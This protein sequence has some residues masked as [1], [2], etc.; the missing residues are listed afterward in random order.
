MKI[1]YT[2]FLSLLSVTLFSQTITQLEVMKSVRKVADNVIRNTTYLYFDMGTGDLINDLDKYGYNKNI[3]PQNGYNDWKYWNGVIHIGFNALGQQTNNE[4]YQNYTQKNFEFF[5]RDFQYLKSL[6]DGKNQWSFPLAQGLNITQLDDC[7]AIGASLIELYMTD[8]KPEYR[9]YIDAAS[10]HIMKKQMRLPDGILSRPKPSLNTVWADDLYMSVPFLS[11]MG[12]LTGDKTYF[13][14]A[15]KQVILFNKYLFEE[16]VG[17]MWHCYYGDIKTNGGAFWGR[18]NGWMMMATADLLRLMPQNH[19]QRDSIISLLSRQI[20]NT[21]QYQSQTGLWHQILNKEDSYLET[22]CTAMFTYAV[23]LAINNG[24][25]DK[26]YKTVALAGWKGIASQITEE[27]AV[28]NICIGTG[29]GDDLKF[30]Y[31]RPTPYN[32]I[33]GL[34]AILLAGMEVYKLVDK[35]DEV[36]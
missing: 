8:K 6:Y 1:R 19:P 18:C 27:G 30:Y 20:R 16:K 12:K 5:F 14:E 2:I 33:H 36:H 22:S 9:A 29:I 32:D 7:G 10:E 26:R 31:Y 24:W 21:A 23:A 34:G 11:R 3:V 35:T 25:I 13:D 4:K 28:T 15:A 17:L